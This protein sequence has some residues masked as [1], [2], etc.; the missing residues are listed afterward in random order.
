MSDPIKPEIDDVSLEA[1]FADAKADAAP[2][3]DL[4]DR[5][6]ADAVEVARPVEVAQSQPGVLARILDALGGWP[7]VSGLATA[8][9][10]GVYLGISD[11]TLL[12][13]VGLSA[14]SEL[15]DDLLFGDDVFFDDLATGEL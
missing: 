14:A 15:T 11:P 2:S 8:A 12:E 9:V 1:I 10:A 5:I 4:M 7:S 6:V 3:V 13:T